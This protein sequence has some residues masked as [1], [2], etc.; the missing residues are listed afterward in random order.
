MSVILLL[1]CSGDFKVMGVVR[2]ACLLVC[3]WLSFCSEPYGGTSFVLLV[4]GRMKGGM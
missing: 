3:V 4:S 1:Y 2:F